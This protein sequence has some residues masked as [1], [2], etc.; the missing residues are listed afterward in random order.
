MAAPGKDGAG[1]LDGI[2]VLDASTVIAA[3]LAAMLLGDFGAD[4]V[5]IEH[6]DG[7]D[8]ARSHGYSKD[9]VPL[10]WLM[11]G[12]NKRSVTLY[13]GSPEG[14][15][16]FRSLARSADVV[17]ENFRPGT[18]ER[19]GLGYDVLSAQNPGL[20][21]AHVSGF[22]RTGPLSGEPGFGTLGEVLS[23]FAFRN[24]DASAPPSLP[25]FGLADGVAGIA[26]ALAVTMALLERERSGRGQEVDATIVEPLLTLLEPQLI[27]QDQLGHTLLRTGNRAEMNAPRGLYETADDQWL[28]ISASTAGTAGRLMDL[29]GAP[30]L[31]HE[32][33]FGSASGRQQHA[34]DLDDHIVPWIGQRDLSVALEVC[35]QHGVPAA[36]VHSAPDIL[37]DEQYD[38]IGSIA[39]ID[40]ETL[41]PVRM[42]DVMFRM[43]RTPGS[44]RRLGASLG[45]HNHEVLSELDDDDERM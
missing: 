29:V 9:G 11:L 25:P 37:R 42:P 19:W 28:A 12:R 38:A 18:M 17:I 31:C 26:T 20:V 15:R 1:L 30:D 6:P 5:K 3:P 36:P 10:W 27:T 23:G 8:P 14:Q 40:H 45:E 22:G 34:Q 2:R 4:V 32:P 41:G 44:I 33:W 7:G 21:M 16:A 13:L 39:R 24:G 43:S 35:R